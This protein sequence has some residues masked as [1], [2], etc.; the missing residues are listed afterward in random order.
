MAVVE[1]ADHGSLAGSVAGRAGQGQG[2]R[3]G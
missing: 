2:T 1:A 3:G